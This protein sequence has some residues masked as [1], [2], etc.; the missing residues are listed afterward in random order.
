VGLRGHDEQG[1]LLRLHRQLARVVNKPGMGFLEGQS[2]TTH[3]DLDGSPDELA[4]L[5]CHIVGLRSHGRSH[6]GQVPLRDTDTSP[7]GTG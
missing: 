6:H 7:T 5:G 3:R 1:E 4:A 2:S